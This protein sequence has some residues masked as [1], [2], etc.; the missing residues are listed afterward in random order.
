MTIAELLEVFLKESSEVP[1]AKAKL[2]EIRASQAQATAAVT[3]QIG[4]LSTQTAE[5]R[6]AYQALVVA[7][8]EEAVKQGLVIDP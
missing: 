6:E 4:V 8:A 3:A 7:I 1:V 2:D 5:A